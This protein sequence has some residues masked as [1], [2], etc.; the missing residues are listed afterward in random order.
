MAKRIVL[1]ALTALR[2]PRWESLLAEYIEGRRNEPFAWGTND[3]CTFVAGC[4]RAITGVD[5]LSDWPQYKTAAQAKRIIRNLGGLQAIATAVLGE[6]R[7]NRGFAQ[8]GDVV[9][10]TLDG[11]ELLGICIG[12]EWVAPGADG[13]AFRPMTEVLKVWAV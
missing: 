12:H 7:E 2:V 3:C 8:R 9:L 5:P 6:A 4:I 13:L 1:Q 11:D 10:A